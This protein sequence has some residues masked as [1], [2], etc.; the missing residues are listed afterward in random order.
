MKLRVELR[1]EQGGCQ[2][3]HNEA[4]DRRRIVKAADPT[5]IPEG[6][7]LGNLAKATMPTAEIRLK[8]NRGWTAADPLRFNQQVIARN[9]FA[10]LRIVFPP[11]TNDWQVLTTLWLSTA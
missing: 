7:T 11:D 10:T 4:D 9:E 6:A 5:G 2:E 8:P 3:L 1:A